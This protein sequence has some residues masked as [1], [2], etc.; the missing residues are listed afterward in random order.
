MNMQ[1]GGVLG[2]GGYLKRVG[3]HVQSA[4]GQPGRQVLLAVLRVAE[5]FRVRG[6]DGSVVKDR[7]CP[8]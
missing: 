6:G 1:R 7:P 4:F 5:F 8:I 3:G 2:A